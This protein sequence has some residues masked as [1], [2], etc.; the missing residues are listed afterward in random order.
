MRY[1]DGN[2]LPV[3]AVRPR[4]PLHHNFVAPTENLEARATPSLEQFAARQQERLQRVSDAIER[5]YGFQYGAV[6]QAETIE[7]EFL[8]QTAPAAAQFSSPSVGVGKL[9]R[10]VPFFEAGLVG[11]H[12]GLSHELILGGEE[13]AAEMITQVTTNIKKKAYT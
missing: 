12:V 9:A 5:N 6:D 3:S 10:E 2:V 13:Q 4:S 8:A 1:N 11:P 7:Q